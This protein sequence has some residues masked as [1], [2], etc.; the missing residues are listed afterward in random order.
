MA[1]RIE[2][3]RTCGVCQVKRLTNPADHQT[4]LLVP[5]SRLPNAALFLQSTEAL[6]DGLHGDLRFTGRLGRS[7]LNA[8][9]ISINA[10]GSDRYSGDSAWLH[11]L[12]FF[13]S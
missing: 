9:Q 3:P 6:G 12:S 8:K 11:R 10:S 5:L 2:L 7:T 1:A 13:S 4:H